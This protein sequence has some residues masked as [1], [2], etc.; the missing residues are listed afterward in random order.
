VNTYKKQYAR[1]N[2]NLKSSLII[3]LFNVYMRLSL[4]VFVYV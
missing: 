3:F 2:T 1:Q 4:S